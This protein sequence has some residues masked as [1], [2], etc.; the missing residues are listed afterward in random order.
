MP[1]EAR[2]FQLAKDPEH[3][4]QCQDAFQIDPVRAVA[5]IADGVGTAIFS[6]QWAS[7]L[8]QAA[9]ADPPDPFNPD[10]FPQWL[11]AQRQN[12][13]K[14]IDTT[15]LAWFQKAKLPLGAFST[16]L[17]IQATATADQQPAGFGEFRL[18][19]FSIGDSCL[20]HLRHG[21]LVQTFPVQTSAEL[22]ADPIVLGSVDLKRDQHL[23]FV[24]LDTL[25]YTDDVLVLCTDA[26]AA[27]ALQL[28]ES[29]VAPPWD[30][31][32][33]V[34]EEEWRAE[35]VGLREQRSMRY[36]DATMLLLRV[37]EKVVEDYPPPPAQAAPA[38]V[39]VSQGIPPAED[40]PL[41]EAPPVVED[42]PVAEYV[43][44][45]EDIPVAEV[46]EDAAS[47]EFPDLEAMGIHVDPR[48]DARRPAAPPEDLSVRFKSLSEQV[49]RGLQKATE[50]GMKRAE[51]G[52]KKAEEGIKKATQ[53]GL[54]KA[55][56]A[57]DSTQSVFRKFFG[58][59]DKK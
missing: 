59:G 56:E 25:C 43:H 2:I 55:E 6:G 45:A 17:W 47:G 54:K 46:V 48:S 19:G 4:D 24:P 12:W 27:W 10:T 14:Q 26:V 16:L 22:E 5:A 53:T 13:A 18:C 51:E 49:S 23:Q 50:V 31:L 9:V 57:K 37:T 30:M 1:L 44:D 29:G 20:F 42:V 36:D 21:D 28:Y 52:I 3:P 33:D 11:Q 8:A 41:A 38:S 32:W 7:L 40:I 34:S 15:G 58:F 39:A 35:V